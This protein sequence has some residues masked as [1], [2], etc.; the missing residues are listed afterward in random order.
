[1]SVRLAKLNLSE[2]NLLRESGLFHGLVHRLLLMKSRQQIGILSEK[3]IEGFLL[4]LVLM[5]CLVVFF[6]RQID[7]IGIDVVEFNLREVNLFLK[8]RNESVSGP[9]GIIYV[10]RRTSKFG[11]RPL[12]GGT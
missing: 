10:G 3:A 8:R 5:L 12:L 11:E 6:P 9:W 7:E 2:V 1:V 4:Q